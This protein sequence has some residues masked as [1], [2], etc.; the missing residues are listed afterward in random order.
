MTEN[1]NKKVIGIFDLHHKKAQP[2]SEEETI[3]KSPDGFEYIIIKS[4]EN[5][6][7]LNAKKLQEKSDKQLYIV[8]VLQNGV[9]TTI[10]KNYK[11]NYF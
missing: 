10:I 8:R 9:G 11:A 4:D 5:G 2:T 1:I 3:H 6:H 7:P